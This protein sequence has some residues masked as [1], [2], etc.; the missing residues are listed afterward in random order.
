MKNPAPTPVRDDQYVR[1]DAVYFPAFV[2]AMRGQV[3][4][5]ERMTRQ[6]VD[7]TI[8]V[9]QPHFSPACRVLHGWAIAVQ[10]GDPAG[11]H[12]GVEFCLAL[13]ERCGVVAVPTLVFY[14][15]VDAGRSL[16]RF[17]FCK[18]TAILAEAGRRLT[19]R[20]R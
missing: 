2:A 19:L 15:N 20:P 8:R 6:I 7:G 13:P 12:D 16:V 4:A 9:E 5:V 11:A 18:Q 14:D 17:A 1:V 3:D 10:S